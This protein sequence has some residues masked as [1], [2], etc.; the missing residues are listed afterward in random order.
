MP[1]SKVPELRLDCALAVTAVVG[2]RR[3]LAIMVAATV[4]T[5]FLMLRA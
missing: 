4:R 2:S 3:E 5:M 1:K